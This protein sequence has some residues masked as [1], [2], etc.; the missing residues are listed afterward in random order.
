MARVDRDICGPRPQNAKQGHNQRI[1]TVG[2][3]SDAITG[4]YTVLVV[5]YGGEVSSACGE[6]GVRR[7]TVASDQRDG[8]RCA[9]GLSDD[10]A[11]KRLF[12]RCR[13]G[14]GL[15]NRGG[16]ASVA[17]ACARVT[18]HDIESAQWRRWMG[19]DPCYGERQLFGDVAGDLGWHPGRIEG[20]VRRRRAIEIDVY[21]RFAIGQRRASVEGRI[22]ADAH[23][24][25]SGVTVRRFWRHRMRIVLENGRHD[26]QQHRGGVSIIDLQRDITATVNSEGHAAAPDVAR[27]HRRQRQDYG[28]HGCIM[29]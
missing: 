3:E 18:M 8:I 11:V 20:D 13:G 16:V 9:G 28:A 19:G 7:R 17:H 6:G 24:A 23:A 15:H 22:G 5:E 29:W 10:H 21:P 25:V 12:V 14:R 27:E 4:T 1:R 2:H 26:R